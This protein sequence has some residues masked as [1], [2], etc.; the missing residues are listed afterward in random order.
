MLTRDGSTRRDASAADPR[1]A[2]ENLTIEHRN[3]PR[4]AGGLGR[5]RRSA[6]ATSAMSGRVILD[7]RLCREHQPGYAIQRHTKDNVLR[8]HALNPLRSHMLVE[9]RPWFV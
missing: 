4:C 7:T 5:N 9:A 8:W 1:P 6:A 2:H 3:I